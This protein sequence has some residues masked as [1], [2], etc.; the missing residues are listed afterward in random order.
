MKQAKDSATDLQHDFFSDVA[1]T[2]HRDH[3][4]LD[5]EHSVAFQHISTFIATLSLTSILDVGCGTGRGMAYILNKFST[6]DVRGIEPVPAMI[7]QAIAQGIP[8]HLITEGRVEA[9]PY[10]DNS[11]DAVCAFAIMHHVPVTPDAIKELIRVARRA[12]FIS[13]SNRFGQGSRLA[14]LL[15]FG[16]WQT[17]LWP[18]VNFIRSRGK[19]YLYWE[20][21]GF[22]YSYSVFDNYRQLA[23]WADELLV[24]PT[25]AAGNRGFRHPLANPMFTASHVLL[26]AIK[27]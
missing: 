8:P 27:K 25:T 18:L 26:C 5:D 17:G 1:R 12:V 21:D 16:A 22:F 11:F 24:I 23:E 20:G 13:D 19:G 6:V 7:D 10:P 15:K 2:Y 4:H 9:L 14:R 3:V